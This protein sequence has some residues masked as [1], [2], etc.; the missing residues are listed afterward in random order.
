MLCTN[1]ILVDPTSNIRL[2][3]RLSHACL[4]THFHKVKPQKAQY[5]SCNSLDHKLS[6]LD[7]CGKSRANTCIKR[8]PHGTR[9]IIRQTNDLRIYIGGTLDNLADRMALCRRQVFQMSALS[10][11]DGS[12]EDYHGCNG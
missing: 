3:Q 5:N 12:I 2:S 1:I 10:T 4:S 9:A 8:G 7:N 6:Y 11:I